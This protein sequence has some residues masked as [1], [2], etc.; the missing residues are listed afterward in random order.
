MDESSPRRAASEGRAFGAKQI[1]PRC[2]VLNNVS[3]FAS[4]RGRRG[5]PSLPRVC[6][7]A[8][9][10]STRLRIGHV[11]FPARLK[12]TLQQSRTFVAQHAAYDCAAV[13]Q[14]GHLQ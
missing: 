5:A 10:H 6:G 7:A 3:I 12:E 11:A 1:P 8:S 9:S 2:G 4:R 13:I 14:A